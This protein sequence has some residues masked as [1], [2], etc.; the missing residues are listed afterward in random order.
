MGRTTSHAYPSSRFERM[1]KSGF[2][3]QVDTARA[4]G[5]EL[6]DALA[7]SWDAGLPAS[8]GEIRP[9]GAGLALPES[10]E[11]VELALF[12]S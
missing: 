11:A 4:T 5:D 9:G 12:M 10:R 7:P 6:L 2:T 1:Q 3:G 8:H